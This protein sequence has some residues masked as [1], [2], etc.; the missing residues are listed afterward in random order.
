MYTLCQSV[1]LSCLYQALDYLKSVDKFNEHIT[2]SKSL[3]SNKM[4]KFSETKPVE[5][6]LCTVFEKVN[7]NELP[8]TLTEDP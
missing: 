1:F 7:E 6:T 5:E 8:F 4:L 2:T 3:P